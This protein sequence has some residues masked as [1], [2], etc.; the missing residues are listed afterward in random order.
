MLIS[1][2]Y[3]IIN[4]QYSSIE[5]PTNLIFHEWKICGTISPSRI[6]AGKKNGFILLVYGDD[7]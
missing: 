4:T 1:G 6:L 5:T 2:E 7:L 3:S